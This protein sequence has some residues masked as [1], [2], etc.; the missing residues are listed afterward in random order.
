[1]AARLLRIP[2]VNREQHAE[3]SAGGV[4]HDYAP[5]AGGAW[6]IRTRHTGIRLSL[7]D[8]HETNHRF[9][10]FA[11]RAYLQLGQFGATDQNDI[12]A[13]HNVSLYG[14]CLYTTDG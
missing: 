3:S 12:Y 5:I 8:R 14:L 1:M 10:A 4:M 2:R 6:T 13:Q 11:V 9:R 7:S